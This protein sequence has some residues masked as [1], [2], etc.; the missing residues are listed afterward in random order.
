[1]KQRLLVL[2]GYRLLQ[3]Q[4][5]GQ[6]KVD[7]VEKAGALKAGIYNIYLATPADKVRTHNGV[8]IHADENFVYQQVGKNFVQYDR[9]SFNTLPASG[10]YVKMRY[11]NDKVIVTKISTRS[12][13]I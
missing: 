1:M 7:R 2:N 6:W 12:I 4:T 13:R 8:V 9:S 5:E 11:E 3:S 10:T